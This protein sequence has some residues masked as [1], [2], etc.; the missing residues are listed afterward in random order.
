MNNI[1]SR[2]T[3][4]QLLIFDWDGTI[5]DSLDHIV[6]AVRFAA[7]KLKLPGKNDKEIKSIIGLGLDEAME[8]L[9]PGT[10]LKHRQSMVE[11]YR[12]HYLSTTSTGTALYPEVEDTLKL[13]R[14]KGYDLAIATGKSRRGLERALDDTGLAEYFFYSRCADETFSK[15]HPQMLD[16]IIEIFSTDRDKVL[17][18]GDSEHD[19][20]MAINAGVSSAAVS[21]GAQNS[22]YLLKFGPLTCFNNLGELPLWLAQAIE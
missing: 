15:P 6:K 8:K 4:Y 19:L 16:D 13:L 3:E 12:Q 1:A 5:A 18:I 11:H 22:E 9:Y 17:M 14:E 7:D 2:Q 20:Q 21:Y 10:E